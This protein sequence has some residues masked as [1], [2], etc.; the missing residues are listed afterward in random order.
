MPQ[1][2]ALEWTVETWGQWGLDSVRDPSITVPGSREQMPRWEMGAAPKGCERAHLQQ[3][4]VGQKGGVQLFHIVEKFNQVDVSPAQ[5]VAHKIV[6]SMTLQHLANGGVRSGTQAR[7]GW[8]QCSSSVSP[9]P[10][11]PLCLTGWVWTFRPSAAP[12]SVRRAMWVPAVPS[13]TSVETRP[14]FSFPVPTSLWLPYLLPLYTPCFCWPHTLKRAALNFI[15][16]PFIHLSLSPPP[17]WAVI[18]PSWQPSTTLS[19]LLQSLYFFSPLVCSPH[20]L[21]SPSG[22]WNKPGSTWIPISLTTLTLTPI[23]PVSV[24]NTVEYII[25]CMLNCLGMIALNVCNLLWNT[26]QNNMFDQRRK[27]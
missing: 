25:I 2:K 10:L 19:K 12:G 8:A 13:S 16:R 6:L 18:P 14:P 22:S 3:R 4:E 5:L 11:P 20:F 7:A 17:P 15:M 21:V 23:P 27:G 26:P 9:A 24:N 1:T